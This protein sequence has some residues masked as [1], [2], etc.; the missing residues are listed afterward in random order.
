MAVNPVSKK[1]YFLFFIASLMK[2]L[3]APV[4]KDQEQQMFIRSEYCYNITAGTY[5]AGKG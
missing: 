2:F 5:S 1:V 3:D 4:I